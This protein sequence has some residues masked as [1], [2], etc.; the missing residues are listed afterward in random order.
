VSKFSGSL[1]GERILFIA[2]KFF[3]YET[4]IAE[5]LRSRGAEVDYFHDRPS[6]G[7]VTKSLIRL[8]RRLIASRTNRYYDRIIEQTSSRDY[9]HILIVRGEAISPER[10]RRL[11]ARHPGAR[12]VLYLWDSM[13]YNANARSLL[14]VV[15]QCF[16]FDRAD[17]EAH[18]SAQFLPLFYSESF[19]AAADWDQDID[20]DAC[21][22]G[23][24]H[25][26]RYRILE[27]MVSN[28]EQ[29]GLRVFVFCYYPSKL[30]YRIRSIFDP[31]FRRF[32]RDNLNFVGMP[33]GSVIDH[34]ARSRSVIDIN[35]PNQLGLTMRTV[36]AVGAQRQ[37]I[38]TNR[39][40]VNYDLYD[41]GAV[42]VV[43]REDPRLPDGFLSERKPPFND[44]L[45]ETY[46]LSAWVDQIFVSALE[47]VGS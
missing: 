9:T 29:Q 41:P 47:P 11:Q 45:R 43:D 8:N 26:D 35:R 33:L 39:D 36:E 37:L 13:H 17:A 7:F 16:T 28:L 24:I 30:L 18:P 31:G 5:H 6:E 42:C 40:V 12:T 21:F 27:R 10:V 25:T 14:G 38:T 23:T 15:D 19:G 44:S 4:L 20:Y 32:G 22:I 1:E 46:S 2:P 3:G 34:F